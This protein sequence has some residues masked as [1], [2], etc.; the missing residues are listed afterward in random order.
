[1]TKVI[2]NCTRTMHIVGINEST[3]DFLKSFEILSNVHRMLMPLWNSPLKFSFSLI[4]VVLWYF[5][6]ISD[7]KYLHEMFSYNFFI[8]SRARESFKSKKRSEQ[9][10][11][12]KYSDILFIY[13]SPYISF[14][15]ELMKCCEWEL[16]V[17]LLIFQFYTKKYF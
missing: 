10:F 17:I 4:L 13:L 3:I 2:L 11:F 5:H 16:W 12:C 7:S 15:F 8:I 1:M 14:G 6:F 9:K